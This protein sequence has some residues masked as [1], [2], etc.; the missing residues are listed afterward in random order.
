M[1]TRQCFIL[2]FFICLIC[3]VLF[4]DEFGEAK[5]AYENG[6]VDQAIDL[7][8]VKLRKD[9]NHKNAIAMMKQ[10]LPV[11]YEKHNKA[12]QE[13]ESKND[14]DSAVNEYKMIKKIVDGVNSITPI[15]VVKVDN[16]KVTKPV[17][18]QKIDVDI[19][20]E[21]AVL[22][23]A[24][25][26]YQKG[27][28]FSRTLGLS[29]D[30]AD[31]FDIVRSYK[32]YYK[33]TDTLAAACLYRDGVDLVTKKNYKG[34]V[35]KF[36]KC[37]EYIPWYK[38]A[39]NLAEEAKKNAIQR[40][41]IMP[42]TNLSGKTQFGEIGQIIADYTVTKAI[43]QQNEF[44]EF[45]TREYVNQILQEQALG[46][47]AVIDERSAAK[48]GKLI[49]INAF[50]FGKVL[51]ITTSYPSDIVET[52]SNTVQTY[53]FSTKQSYP[54][55]CNY[56]KH[57]RTGYVEI[58]GSIQIIDVEKGT[59]VKSESITE[60][61]GDRAQWVTYSGSEDAIPENVRNWATESAERSLEPAEVLINK[62][63]DIISQKLAI[64]L[65]QFF[66]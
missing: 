57:T 13:Y 6:R 65:T 25:L 5:K 39:A 22:N 11:A 9:N 51:T 62:T 40:I 7:L 36:R 60:R 61:T 32:F 64:K 31:E 8:V 24:E 30:A 27:L 52:G 1:K 56:I 34:A 26:H 66:Q 35:M 3:S 23:A 48:V 41:A 15:E 19:K 17:E 38:D 49:G 50:I 47:A 42:F 20:Y 63:I 12:A 58:S 54:Q 16:K 28:L 53:N 55:S 45:V 29:K 43:Q 33:N 18:L 21:N 14:W 4:A 37:Q 59:I 44:L 2:S 10:V 46:Q